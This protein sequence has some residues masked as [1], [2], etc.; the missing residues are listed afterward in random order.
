LRGPCAVGQQGWKK[1]TV[2]P[3]APQERRR[4]ALQV[5]VAAE[6]GEQPLN[7]QRILEP[8]VRKSVRGA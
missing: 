4:H 6:L 8:G 5:V 1:E 3:D 2:G 7:R